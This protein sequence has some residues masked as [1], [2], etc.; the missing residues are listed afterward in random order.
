MSEY[1]VKSVSGSQFRLPGWILTRKGLAVLAKVLAML[2]IAIRLRLNKGF[3]LVNLARDRN[4][5]GI[6][7]LFRG[8]RLTS[9][10]SG[11]VVV[12]RYA[13]DLVVGFQHRKHA[14][15]FLAESKERL[16]SFP[17]ELHP[18]KT[19]LIEFGRFA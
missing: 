14:E 7:S 4:L 3:R 12:V 15:R 13:D 19:R 10:Q 2:N 1:F 18:D 11:E 5:P 9:E 8:F 17:L 6:C 16:A